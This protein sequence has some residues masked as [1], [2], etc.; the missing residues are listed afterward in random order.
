[1]CFLVI[2]TILV[3]LVIGYFYTCVLSFNLH[4]EEQPQQIHY[5]SLYI[6][7]LP[8]FTYGEAETKKNETSQSL[9]FFNSRK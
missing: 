9:L 5:C 4:L 6:L 7:L 8:I 2:G 1:M 3:V